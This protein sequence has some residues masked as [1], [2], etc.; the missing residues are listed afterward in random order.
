MKLYVCGPMSNLPDKNFPAFNRAAE[1]LRSMGYEVVNPVDIN[2]NPELP[3]HECMKADIREMVLCDGLALLPGHGDSIGA[4]IEMNLALWLRIECQP[5]DVWLSRR[6][7][8][9]Q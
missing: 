1:L 5:L 2:P 6:G 7:P 9:V 3:W 4:S 8:V